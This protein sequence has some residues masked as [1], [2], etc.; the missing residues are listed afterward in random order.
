MVSGI[1]LGVCSGFIRDYLG[2]SRVYLGFIRDLSGFSL[3]YIKGFVGK[4]GG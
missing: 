4:R 2:F 3:G 1:S